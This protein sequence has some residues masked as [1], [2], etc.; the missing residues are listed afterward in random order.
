MEKLSAIYRKVIGILLAMACVFLL[1]CG[2]A[3]S[4]SPEAS[5]QVEVASNQAEVAS[6]ST[7]VASDSTTEASNLATEPGT[8]SKYRCIGYYAS[9]SGYAR[10]YGLEEVDYSKITHLNFAFANLNSDGSVVVGDPWIDVQN[11][12]LCADAGFT[13]ENLSNNTAGHFGILKKLK[14]QYPNLKTL[15]SIGGWS[16]SNH[17]SA[18]AADDTKRENMA[19]TAVAFILQYGFDGIDIDW[20]YPVEGEN[21]ITYSPDDKENFLKLVKL[22]REKLDAQSAID[23]K[24]YL[25]TIAASAN[26]NYVKNIDVKGMLQYL[27]WINIMTYDY[28]G[29][30]DVKT[31]HNT[32]L[33]LNSNDTS[34][35]KFNIDTTV[36]KYLKAGANPSDLNLGLAFYGRGWINVDATPATC[37]FYNGSVA[38]SAG[39]DQGTWQGSCWDYWDIKNNYIGKRGYVRYWDDYAK[40]PYLFSEQ[41]KVFITYDDTESLGYKLEYLKSKKLGGAM[42]W[43]FSGDDDGEL[44]SYIA[45]SLEI[46][47]VTPSATTTPIVK[48]Q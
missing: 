33:Y 24:R 34:G 45:N 35:T 19:S 16:W 37:L 7:E 40:C 12:Q 48:Q 2:N 13:L 1:A 17:F 31:N 14:Q 20:E 29:A 39:A 11:T 41:N 10:N 46:N 38:A 44:L 18:V 8:S 27:D 5:K 6:D 30:F 32:P 9:W 47:T 3:S 21:I 42:F 4:M 36:N 43:E 28:H 25:L 15:I 22:I 26:Q 23:G